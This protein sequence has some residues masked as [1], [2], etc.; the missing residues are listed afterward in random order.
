VKDEAGQAPR[1][2]N[3]A[4]GADRADEARRVEVVYE[5]GHT[6]GEPYYCRIE[7]VWGE[8]EVAWVDCYYY[9]YEDSPILR[10]WE[11][12]ADADKE[13]IEEDVSKVVL[14]SVRYYIKVL[15]EDWEL[16]SDVRLRIVTNDY[17][18]YELLLKE[19][20]GE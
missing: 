4:E 17:D 1:P 8:D 6:W 15:E 12:D 10:C 3:R 16:G 18:L 14:E 20:G 9:V 2:A 13:V 7:E 11:S 19:F 5:R